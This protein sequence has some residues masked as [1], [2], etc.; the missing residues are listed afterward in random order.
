MTK[1]NKYDFGEKEKEVLNGIEL[2]VWQSPKYK[3]AKKGVIDILESEK[4]KNVLD[5][6][7]FWILMNTYANKTKMMYTGLIISHNGCLKI[8][9]LLENK[10]NPNCLT[11]D[12]EGYN[13]SLV[14]T[15]KDEDVYEV[16]EVSKENCKNNYP[17]AMALK[18]CFDRVVLKKCKLAYKGIYSDSE[19]D[20]FSEKIEQKE[21]NIEYEQA[22]AEQIKIIN[23]YYNEKT[24]KK[25]LE[26]YE[27]DSIERLSIEDASELI[28]SIKNAINNKKGEDKNE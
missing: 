23:K 19:A 18:R 8:N 12:K 9:D 1:E 20:E 24:I 10:F 17:Y 22:T 7:D 6:S 27:V 3:E 26:H 5:V 25:I 13:N 11:L 14:Y 4:Y 15:Y 16:G 21:D 2:P 28:K